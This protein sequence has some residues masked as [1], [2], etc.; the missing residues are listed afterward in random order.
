MS[1]ASKMALG[2]STDRPVLMVLLLP[3]TAISCQQVSVFLPR[4]VPF[5]PWVWLSAFRYSPFAWARYLAQRLAMF[6]PTLWTHQRFQLLLWALF[7]VLLLDHI[8]FSFKAVQLSI[9]MP[10]WVLCLLPPYC[11]PLVKWLSKQ[12]WL[13]VLVIRFEEPFTTSSQ[14]RKRAMACLPAIHWR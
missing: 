3:T 1:C 9:S 5:E 2:L 7:W 13:A 8:S 6:G 14:N 4:L 11:F 10:Q 12:L